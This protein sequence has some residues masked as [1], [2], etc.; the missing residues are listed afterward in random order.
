M[1]ELCCLK[2]VADVVDVVE[3]KPVIYQK[4]ILRV[5]TGFAAL[6]VVNERATV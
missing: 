4:C 1:F 3:G 2:S 5:S 6:G